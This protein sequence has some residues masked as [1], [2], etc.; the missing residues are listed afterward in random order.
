MRDLS[1]W[2][3]PQKKVIKHNAGN[4]LVSAS[5]G[6][7]KTSVLIEKIISLIIDGKISLKKL[8]VVTFTNSASL[9]I[10]QRL[11][12]AI[13][14]SGDDKLIKELEN[15]VASDILTF[16]A[17]CIKVIKEFGREIGQ[18]PNFSVAD[19]VLAG[20]LKNQA[21]DNIFASHNKNLDERF[22][23]LMDSFFD[24]RNDRS[25]RLSITK[26]YDFLRSKNDDA[27]Y[28]NSLEEFYSLSDENKAIK[29]LNNH[30][31]LLRDNFAGE[32][33]SL[34]LQS[35]AF[36][37]EQ[38]SNAL[39]DAMNSVRCLD[40]DFLH[41]LNILR[42]GF[43]FKMPNKSRKDIAEIIDI[44]EKFLKLKNDFLK[45]IWSVMPKE[46]I[47]L[48]NEQI[49]RDLQSTK[50]LIESL[51][52]I[53][54][55][56]DREYSRIKKDFQVLDFNDIE[57]LSAEILKNKEVATAIQNRYDWI[58]ID[59]YQDTS[60]LQENIVKQITTGDNLFMVGD[61]KQSIY[62]FRQA[63]P[64]IFI[65]KYNQYKDMKNLGSVLEL[66]TNFRSED[67]I[68]DF[69]N[70]VFDHIYKKSLDDFEYR[71]NADLEFGGK[72]KKSGYGPQVKILALDEREEEEKE[73]LDSGIYSVKDAKLVFDTEKDIQREALVL[74]KQIKE[75]LGKKYYDAKSDTFKTISYGDIA[76]LSRNKSGVLAET[77]KILKDV[78]IP[79]VATFDDKLFDNFDM[80]I[81]MSILKTIQNPKD[82]IPLII[83]LSNVGG[84]DFDELAKI[85]SASRE[86]EF[87]HQSL[88]EYLENFNDTT[89]QKI[90]NFFQ[91][92]ERYQIESSH[93]DI[94]ELILKIVHDENLDT[95][96]A[97]NDKGA[98]FE[99]HLALLIS[100]IQSVKRYSLSEFL[101]FA[102][103]F[104]GEMHFDTT[105]KDAEDAVILST[106]HSSK[107]LEYPVV[108]LIA[109]GKKFNAQSEREKILMD[110]DWGISL[111]SFDYKRHI[112]YENIIKK[113]FKL[114]IRD[115]SRKEEK[116]LL[117]VALT[118]PK[119][120]LTV[121]GTMK[122]NDIK[123]QNTD[124]EI[125][126]S[127][128][129]L[130]WI[131][132][133]LSN[134]E[135]EKLKLD[136]SYIKELQN[137][138]MI[139]FE[140]IKDPKF[141]FEREYSKLI[142]REN[143]QID[144]QR[145]YDILSHGFPKN[146]LAKKNSVTQIMNEE[147]HYNISNFD[148]MH[149]DRHWDEDFLAVGTAY[150]KFM[151]LIDF[152]NDE[153]D[154]LSQIQMML[155]NQ[156]ISKEEYDLVDKEK[157]VVAIKELSKL[158]SN[159]DI[160]LKE[161]QFLSYMPAKSFV[162]T[163]KENKILVQGVAD[164][165]VIKKSEIYLI[166]YKTSR[167]KTDADFQNKYATQLDIYGKSIESFYNMPVT[168][169]AIYSFYLNK[170][171]F[172][173]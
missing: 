167:L 129:Y 3:E 134:D 151:E 94:A 74:A 133:T 36:D 135:L 132:G 148:Y 124:Y 50:N 164:L 81:L 69:N 27:S 31:L 153:Q 67:C 11:Q 90:K 35:L 28:K 13:I 88:K 34:Y 152:S 8:L 18:D 39:C 1:N 86:K 84:F 37:N 146:N 15:L 103:S 97:I 130:S 100:N 49:E 38:V 25:L 26:L 46:V 91:K 40:D 20:F 122:Q 7:G 42:A 53:T 64:K 159:Q 139:D 112:S 155:D 4:L 44:K 114:K 71:G 125:S 9:E 163:E 12:K 58:F 75:V 99:N 131:L 70:F 41:N 165:V 109:G 47:K 154:I 96:F 117:Y 172:I 30:L 24:S 82:D 89:S 136:N 59:E 142:K 29:Y 2:T 110:N 140:Y 77:R 65:N 79:T 169:K 87:F 56:F 98:E 123:S 119:N 83:S 138:T 66:K 158:I 55:E 111:S 126:K 63:E 76:V 101:N 168:K 166:D 162:R 10:K 128:S 108:F 45:D 85:R 16:D 170:L 144:K 68:L 80:Q 147:E 32:V 113:A 60:M 5:A 104:G 121:I 118:R 173:V 156:R 143:L 23:Q 19:T 48:T 157:I 62:R 171:V 145:F 22:V 106:V 61:F 115:E 33:K 160:V 149:S 102:S 120:Y 127:Q 116:R 93:L 14:N 72:S 78:G 57:R 6:S 141:D 105:Y 52:D 137:K 161:Q 17:F 54:D 95:Y 73:S 43:D 107:G 150:H 21:L 92:I 51:F